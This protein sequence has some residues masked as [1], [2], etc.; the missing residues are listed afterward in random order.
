[1]GLTK[2]HRISITLPD[3]IYEEIKML[4]KDNTYIPYSKLCQ[5]AINAG[6]KSLKKQ[7]KN[8]K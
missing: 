4:K 2:T 7:D 1:M 5:N 6:I 3:D 8:K